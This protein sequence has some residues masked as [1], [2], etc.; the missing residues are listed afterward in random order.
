MKIGFSGRADWL[1]RSFLLECDGIAESPQAMNQVS[2]QVMFVEFVEVD[3]RGSVLPTGF[4]SSQ[5]FPDLQATAIQ[6]CLY[7]RLTRLHG[8]AR[9]ITHVPRIAA[10][11]SIMTS[12]K[13]IS[14]LRRS[15]QPRSTLHR[16]WQGRRTS[17]RFSNSHCKPRS[18]SI[19]GFSSCTPSR[20]WQAAQ[21]LEIAWPSALMCD[22]SWQRKQPGESL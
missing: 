15:L 22:P 5:T 4:L 2:S 21:S 9:R 3:R 20:L 16:R 13:L 19:L 14:W 6:R 12:S 8:Q 18:T 7:H 10:G 1:T 17:R 11:H